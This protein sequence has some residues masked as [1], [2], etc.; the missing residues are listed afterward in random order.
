[1]ASIRAAGGSASAAVV[2]AVDSVAVSDFV[3]SVAAQGSVDISLNVIS[4]NDVQGTPIVDMSL[5]DY[6][7]PVV[8]NVSSKFLTSQ[9]AARHMIR[10]R[11]GVIMAFGGSG[12]RAVV[13]LG[14]LQTG[15]DAVE[16]LRR[17]LA[18]ELGPYGVRVVTL[19]TGG[20]PSTIPASL[21]GRAEIVSYLE[22][23]TVTGRTAT[24]E[25][26]GHVAVFAASDWARTM[27]GC[28]LN[29]TAGAVLDR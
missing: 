23:Q 16:S 24:L 19:Q 13:N 1:M 11:S 21:P 17:Q 8:T 4:D 3:D 22:G 27:T 14:G 9:A 20:V 18:V 2:D 28:A 7:A 26:V 15:F 12:D 5:A 25:D 29:M 6:L 10:Q